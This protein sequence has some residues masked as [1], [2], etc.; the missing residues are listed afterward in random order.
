MTASETGNKNIETG[1]AIAQKTSQVFAD[2]ASAMEQIVEQTQQISLNSQQQ[3]IAT[4]QVTSA[5]THLTSDANESTRGVS[6]IKS[7]MVQLNQ[8]A[9]HLKEVI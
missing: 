4:Q 8:A 1:V 6:P 9:N 2:V 5:I 3:A 7:G